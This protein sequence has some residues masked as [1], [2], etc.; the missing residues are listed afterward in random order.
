MK[1][2]TTTGRQPS[3]FIPCGTWMQPSAPD[4]D[5]FNNNGLTAQ[6]HEQYYIEGEIVER[7]MGWPGGWQDR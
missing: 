7:C 3:T 2:M 6:L 5:C 4:S 1:V